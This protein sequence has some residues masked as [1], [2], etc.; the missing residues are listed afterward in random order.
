MKVFDC[1]VHPSLN[2][3]QDVFPYIASEWQEHFSRQEFKI[4]GRAPERYAHPGVPLRADATPPAGGVPASDPEFVRSDLLDGWEVDVA[5]LLPMQGLA[6]A[7]WT[8]PPTAHAWSQA[9][10]D[11][12]YDTWVKR[13][14]RFRL[15]LTVSP[16][17]PVLAAT[18][19]ARWAGTEGVM[20]VQLPLVNV[21]MGNRHYYPIYEAAEK[22]GLPIAVH[23]TGAE[24][25]YLGTPAVAGGI[26]RTYGERHTMLTQVGQ[27]SVTSLMF[28]GVFER[29]PKLKVAFI[30][31]G[32][33]WMLPLLWRLDREWKNFRSETPWVKR[34]P[35]EY[36]R[37]HVRFST[38]PMDEPERVEDFQ[39]LFEMLDGEQLLMF[40]SDYPHYDNDDPSVIL[41]KIPEFARQRVAMDNAREFFGDR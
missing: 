31:Y 28:E 10:N 6:I 21:L 23:Q 2:G 17:D 1:D 7:A 38:Q 12:F 3:P 24:G 18:E 19:I 11:Y 9:I 20:S 36:I 25:C 30:E 8:D 5:M 32:F 27:S 14:E 37:E 13:D 22:A 15:A 40:S 26:P 35:R 39:R 33:S 41:K 34:P 29:F 4:S 16:H